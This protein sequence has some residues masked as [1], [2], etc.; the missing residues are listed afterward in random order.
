M[1]GTTT[2]TTA[3][4]T[5]GTTTGDSSTSASGTMSSERLARFEQEVAG[6]KVG[7]GGSNP[8]RV[9]TIIGIALGVVGL[10]VA[11]IGY[12]QA[13]SADRNEF[14]FR[15]QILTGIGLAIALIGAVVWIRNSITRYMRWWL[16]RLV[17]EQ[18]E[19]TDRLIE[20]MRN[21]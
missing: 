17:Y 20:A 1:A 21:R 6:L 15:Y 14:I 9:G 16:V 11:V 19:Q 7:V 8:E 13:Q 2:G 4:T 3:D 18:R 10:V 12:S 5:P